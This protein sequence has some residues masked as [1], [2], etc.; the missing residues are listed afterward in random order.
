MIYVVTNRHLVTKE[1]FYEAIE[2]CSQAPIDGIILREKDLS[3]SKLLDMA[4]KVKQITNKYNLPLIV[5]GN[6]KVAEKINAYGCHFG[7]NVLPNEY[8]RE[9]L[10]LGI[11]IHSIGEAIKAEKLGVDYIIAGNIF[12]TDCKPGLVGRGIEFIDFIKRKVSILVI[13]IGGIDIDNIKNVID[14]GADGVAIMSSA[15]KDIENK[16]IKNLRHQMDAGIGK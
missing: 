5:N 6:E 12:E 16:F 1:S 7:Y 10:R 13:A 2:R 15:M 14:S 3:Y 4:N 9:G 11:S 8:N